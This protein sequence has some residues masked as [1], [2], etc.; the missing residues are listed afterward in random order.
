MA[1]KYRW[2]WNMYLRLMALTAR[3]AFAATFPSDIIF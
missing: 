2:Q 1:Q 3:A